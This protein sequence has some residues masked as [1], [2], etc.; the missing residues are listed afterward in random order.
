MTASWVWIVTPPEVGFRGEEH[1]V[2]TA[3]SKSQGV[4]TAA[5]GRRV[6]QGDLAV[7]LLAPHR[8]DRC[9]ALVSGEQPQN[10]P[11]T[12]IAL[13]LDS[14]GNGAAS[15]VVHVCSLGEDVD[16]YDPKPLCGA[17]LSANA[18][19]ISRLG[20]QPCQSCLI[21]AISSGIGRP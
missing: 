21:H 8:C 6:M 5:C 3:A 15:Q 19:F 11:D 13:C 10:L 9:L 12:R 7:G 4:A 14:A 18:V 17:V 20:G 16:E 1:A 2:T